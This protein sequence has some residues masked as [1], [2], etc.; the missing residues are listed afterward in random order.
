MVVMLTSI[1]ENCM[2]C[3]FMLCSFMQIL[4]SMHTSCTFT[5][6][7]LDEIHE[8]STDID[9]TMLI[10]R[11]LAVKYPELK[12]VLMS[13]TLQG[14]LFNEYFQQKL[15][16]D[17]VASPVFVGMMRFPVTELCIDELDRLISHKEDQKQYDAMKKLQHQLKQFATD[18]SVLPLMEAEVSSF[19]QDVCVN[20]LISQPSPGDSI[21]VFLPGT[22]D[23]SDFY[24]YFHRKARNLYIRDRFRIFI[25]H[26]QAPREDQEEAFME[27]IPGTATIILANRS[28]ESSLTFPNLKMVVNFGVSKVAVYNTQQ[29]VTRLT[30]RWCS[31][32]SC[33]QRAGRVGRVS[34]GI[35]IHLIPRAFYEELPRFNPPEIIDAPLSKTFLKAKDICCTL[36]MPLPSFLLSSV[37]QPPTLIQFEAALHDL[38]NC[39][40]LVH[41]PHDKISEN[42]DTTLLGRFSASVPLDLSLC[43]LIF[44]GILFGCPLDGVVFAAAMSMYQDVFTLPTKRIMRELD[45]FCQS[46][47][48]STLTRMKFDDHCYSNPIMMRNMFIEWLKFKTS[49]KNYNSSRRQVANRFCKKYAVRVGRLLHFEAYVADIARCVMECAPSGSLLHLEL[50]SLSKI[51]SSWYGDPQLCDSSFFAEDGALKPS[52]RPTY[53]KY[54][55]P[56]LRGL[57]SQLRKSKFNTIHFCSSY[58]VLKALI[59]AAST[60]FLCGERACESHRPSCKLAAQRALKMMETEQFSVHR[61]LAMDLTELEDLD[62]WE[63]EL[64]KT[65]KAALEKLFGSLPRGYRFPVQISTDEKMAI[66]HFQPCSLESSSHSLSLI[67]SDIGISGGGDVASLPLEVEFYW[68]FGEQNAM[69]EIDNVNSRFPAPFHPCALMWYK[70]TED[71]LKINSVSMNW[72]NPTAHL[73]L[74]DKPSMPCLA[75]ASKLLS[76]SN[77][78]SQLATNI[79]LLPSGPEG[80]FILLAFQPSTSTVELLVD[81]EQKGVR[82]IKINSLHIP[83]KEI[84]RLITSSRLDAINKLRT[85]I[86]TVMTLPLSNRRI[87]L[88]NSLIKQIPKLLQNVLT[89]ECGTPRQPT[90]LYADPKAYQG[91]YTDLANANTV[92]LMWETVSPGTLLKSNTPRSLSSTFGFPEYHC[93]ILGTKPYSSKAMQHDCIS[94]VT[95]SVTYTPTVAARIL[96]K[97]VEQRCSNDS[98]AEPSSGSL[99]TIEA[100]GRCPK[101]RGDP[102][103]VVTLGNR[104]MAQVWTGNEE[105]KQDVSTIKEPNFAKHGQLKLEQ[106]VVRYL[107]RNNKMEFFSELV[108]QRRINFLCTTYELSFDINFFHCRPDIFD[109]KEIKEDGE[110]EGT[111]EPEFLI[112]LHPSRWDGDDDIEDGEKPLFTKSMQLIQLARSSA[113]VRKEVDSQ[114]SKPTSSK[115]SKAE[116]QLASEVQG[117]ID[118]QVDQEPS[119][120]DVA[121]END[122]ATLCTAIGAQESTKPQATI[123]GTNQEDSD[124][125]LSENAIEHSHTDSTQPQD[126]TV[127]T[128]S[129]AAPTPTG[130]NEDDL[131]SPSVAVNKSSILSNTGTAEIHTAIV[132]TTSKKE[133][134]KVPFEGC[135]EEAIKG[136]ASS[137]NDLSSSQTS[138]SRRQENPALGACLP[139]H[140]EPPPP[141]CSLPKTESKADSKPSFKRTKPSQPGTDEHLA[142][143]LMDVISTHGGVMRL[144]F[145]KQEYRLY[146]DKYWRYGTQPFLR[147]AFLASRPERFQFHKEESGMVFV[148]VVGTRH[149]SPMQDSRTT[150][151][152]SQVPVTAAPL[153]HSQH[154]EENMAPA[155]SVEDM[156]LQHQDRETCKPASAIIVRQRR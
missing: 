125:T 52:L 74:I 114:F 13:A 51:E 105:T 95:Y 70:L 2:L 82:E 134:S 25:F 101:W 23:I 85:G 120:T 4:Q 78:F 111:S 17:V 128:C 68:R 65:D 142:N 37:I 107:Q 149:S 55:P 7:I 123:P 71:R 39:G 138:G 129:S 54:I 47:A 145:L 40:A 21:L 133:S 1:F 84:D 67:A 126:C 106:E 113:S 104:K 27:P 144:A 155:A 87:P 61:S 14:N 119:G 112:V 152:H 141:I 30:R 76:T 143:Y 73:C 109:V 10:V 32:A 146:H 38:A 117:H 15:C 135:Q 132:N 137:L 96:A 24:D 90:S 11:Q 58:K 100:K 99:Q 64:D 42:A 150:K 60:T 29:H 110:T 92:N 94:P 18:P 122:D 45:L 12:V 36:G 49:A 89:T 63:E 127:A 83:C 53:N 9:F 66:V 136:S 124:K 48:R 20:L 3:L 35:A 140:K 121:Q 44:L 116:G 153:P 72:R 19:A 108:V 62:L 46:L 154:K 86:S 16:K 6:I 34:E 79:T 81:I 93:S 97:Q 147:K 151:K 98:E 22:S 75:V 41:S 148:R 8:R 103:N 56:A 57:H 26:N 130:Q 28:A 31:H 69:W 131:K 59:A 80:L 115:A 88:S 156:K 43:R 102:V 77:V 33:I 91:A 118:R 50:D 5:H 139:E